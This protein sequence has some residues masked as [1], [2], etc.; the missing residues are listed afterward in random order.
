MVETASN[1]RKDRHSTA[2]PASTGPRP[3]PLAP[4]SPVKGRP[5]SKLPV[6]IVL[7]ASATKTTTKTA[8]IAMMI[9]FALSMVVMPTMLRTVTSA[10]DP[11]NPTHTGIEGH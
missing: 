8:W 2:A 11:R 6:A 9:E 5:G 4:P 10:S 7:I 3:T 1:P